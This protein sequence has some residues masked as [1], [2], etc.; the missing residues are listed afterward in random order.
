LFQ[1][2]LLTTTLQYYLEPLRTSPYLKSAEHTTI[3]SNIELIFPCHQTILQQ[4][5][6]NGMNV[7]T[8]FV[9]MA[10]I[11]KMYT[12]YC[13]NNPQSTETVKRLMKSSAGFA[14]FIEEIRLK[15]EELCRLDLPSYLIKP[16]QRLCKY[17][18]LMEQLKRTTDKNDDDYAD[19]DTAV[20]KINEIVAMVNSDKN[21]AEH[22]AKLVQ[23]NENIAFNG[24]DHPTTIV[25]H[26]RIIVKEGPLKIVSEKGKRSTV[27]LVLFNDA[28]LVLRKSKGMGATKKYRCE[29]YFNLDNAYFATEAAEEGNPLLVESLP[30]SYL[31]QPYLVHR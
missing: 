12:Q 8:V 15:N 28:I 7:G 3:F 24:K 4:L 30:G 2:Q 6:E 21:V 29:I 25:T 1:L 14:N 11:F 9:Q 23:L 13:T 19:L 22:G 18:L 17:P 26:G 5:E 31:L 10:D 27:N 16:I 20:R